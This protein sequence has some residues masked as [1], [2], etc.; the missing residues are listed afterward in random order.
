[1]SDWQQ[2]RFFCLGTLSLVSMALSLSLHAQ[3]GRVPVTGVQGKAPQLPPGPATPVAASTN[4]PTITK[5]DPGKFLVSG[6]SIV[7]ITGTNF[8]GA[9]TV[10]FGGTASPQVTV[11]DANTIK[12]KMPPHLVG[13]V[14]VN[15]QTSGQ[16]ASLNNSITF[17][18][19]KRCW[20]FP[21][22]G[23]CQGDATVR[24]ANINAF[25][26]NTGKLTFFDQIKS[27][28]NGA[29]S[30]A[31]VSADLT[32]LNFSNGMQI[33]AGTNL[34]AGSSNATTTVV[35]GATPVLSANGAAQAAQNMLY[36][37]N[38]VV[39]AELPAV[40]AGIQ[41]DSPGGIGGTLNVVL[42][43]GVDVQ[44][45][46]SGTSTTVDSPSS[47]GMAGMEGYLVYNSINLSP[48][49]DSKSN[50]Y[51]GS[52]FLGGSYGYSYTSHDYARD[53][54]F[55]SVNRGVGQASAGILINNVAKISVSRGFG[56]SQVYQDSTSGIA[57]SVNNFKS[58]SFGITY[59][60]AAPSSKGT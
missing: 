49:S 34:Q 33:T 31:T 23:M 51:A 14:T 55:G 17:V 59:Q 12:A 38:F 40:G 27:I 52:I 37:G 48:G 36:G 8:G 21:T 2:T 56:P 3:S 5:I 46:K 35:P 44:N 54:G 50:I 11:Q 16:S 58:W 30:S 32:T 29:S 41:T 4:A 60:S 25:Y 28:Y 20:L 22:V 19:P 43:E 24:E 10:D 18:D 6:G 47:H 42:Q 26:N 9:T 15:V 53:Y 57:K 13:T 7:T 1:M 45:F 39:R